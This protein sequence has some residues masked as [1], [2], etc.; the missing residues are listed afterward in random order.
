[1][2]L[3]AL[4]IFSFKASNVHIYFHRKKLIKIC[5]QR[6]FALVTKFIA[7]FQYGRLF[8]RNICFLYNYKIL[9]TRNKKRRQQGIFI[10]GIIM[11]SYIYMVFETP[12]LCV[13]NF[14]LLCQESKKTEFPNITTCLTEAHNE[15]SEG[16]QRQ[17]VIDRIVHNKSV[18]CLVGKCANSIRIKSV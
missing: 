8:Y 12:W 10:K 17:R 15:K 4:K 16:L 3:S 18:N 6:H 2:F 13:G 14:Q 1:M 5:F 11:L 9:S 7:K